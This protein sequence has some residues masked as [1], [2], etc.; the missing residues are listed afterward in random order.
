MIKL[1][2]TGYGQQAWINRPVIQGRKIDDLSQ[3]CPICVDYG[4]SLSLH[5][6]NPDDLLDG[7]RND[8][9]C[10]IHGYPEDFHATLVGKM[11]RVETASN[12]T[13]D[14]FVTSI[15]RGSVVRAFEVD[16][17]SGHAV[18]KDSVHRIATSVARFSIHEAPEDLTW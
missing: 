18:V 11:L 17:S 15:V 9:F 3:T 8:P 6:I 10:V 5:T 2:R 14:Y 7:E 1:M 4:E 12:K 16:Y 13:T